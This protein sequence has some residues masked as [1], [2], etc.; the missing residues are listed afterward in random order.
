MARTAIILG[1]TGGF[2]S[3][4]VQILSGAGWTI[5]A[6]ARDAERLGA[7]KRSAADVQTVALDLGKPDAILQLSQ[8]AP[9][10]DLIVHAAT[11]T[12]FA[13]FCDL[14][15]KTIEDDVSLNIS[16]LVALLAYYLPSMRANRSG[17]VLTLSSTA[18]LRAAPGIAL[19]AAAKNFAFSL[20]KSLAA[21]LQAEG[22]TLTCCVAGPMD[23]DFA[24]RAGY[25]ASGRGASPHDVAR[26]ALDA[27]FAGKTIV[28][29]GWNAMLRAFIYRNLP[30][31]L[32]GLLWRARA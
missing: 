27:C 1:A 23:T 12:R 18:A 7:L 24:R 2:G 8:I 11:E 28:Y 21:E 20:T 9:H 14:P 4:C 17:A 19:Y 25:P 26:R 32:I 6:V 22:V 16:S 31:W 3:A 5:I 29:S 30:N 15:A 13:P 10:A